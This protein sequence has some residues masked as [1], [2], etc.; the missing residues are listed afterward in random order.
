MDRVIDA[1]PINS[2]RTDPG[3][4]A[5][6][7]TCA[8]TGGGGRR[9]GP[10]PRRGAR[11]AAW[12]SCSCGRRAWR[13]ARSSRCLRCSPTHAA[14][15]AR[16]WRSTT[17]PTSRSPPEPTSCTSARTTCRSRSPGRSSGP[18]TIIGRSSHSPAQADRRDPS[19]ASTTSAPG[20]SGRR[21]PSQAARH[22]AWRSS[23]TCGPAPARPWFAIGGI[24]PGQPGR[25]AR[26]RRPP[27]GRGARH[28]RG[29]RPGRGSGR[30][31]GPPRRSG[32]RRVNCAHTPRESRQGAEREATA[33]PTVEP[34]PGNAGEGRMLVASTDL[35]TVPGTQA[36]MSS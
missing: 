6:G 24:D 28:H 18:G 5:R 25:R 11:P 34:D 35:Q 21:R 19:L 26:R 29:R 20:R 32:K 17:G 33:P 4:P 13:R 31:R 15:T 27:R 7:S 3:W 36:P 16:C 22:R 2:R 12:T 1:V 30:P 14:G 9:P 10:V 8:P 23:S